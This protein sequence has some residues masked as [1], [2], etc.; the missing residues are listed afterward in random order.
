MF[1]YVIALT[2]GLKHVKD[3]ALKIKTEKV[4]SQLEQFACEKMTEEDKDDTCE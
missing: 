3:P 2:Y 4:I 1:T